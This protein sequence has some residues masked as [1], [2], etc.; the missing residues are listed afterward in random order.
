MTLNV[1]APD[2]GQDRVTVEVR[3]TSVGTQI[4]TDA[5]NADRLRVRTADLQDAL[6]RHGL[7][8]E[9]VRIS[10]TTRAESSDAA[11]AVAGERDG[12]RL[13]A[14]QQ[15]ATGDGATSQGQRERGAAAREWD[16]PESSRQSREEAQDD[17]RQG[18]GQRGRRAPYNGSEQ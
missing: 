16:R 4:T 11:R 9:S 18:A 13:T 8:S 17:A 10:G 14:A 2:G 5:A 7:D 15:S 3:G 12:L 6:G 1:D